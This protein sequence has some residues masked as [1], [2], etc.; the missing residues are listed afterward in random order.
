MLEIESK[1]VVD[2][3]VDENGDLILVKYDESTINAGSV[4]GPQGEQGPVGTMPVGS[5]TMFAGVTAPAGW[6]F[7]NGAE[8]DR[9]EYP[10][11]FDAIGTMYGEGD[12]ETTFNLPNMNGRVPVGLNESDVDFDTAGKTGGE[13][14]HTLTVSE[15]PSHN[16]GGT[17]GSGGAHDH[18]GST[19]SGG[20]HNH[21]GTTGSSAVVGT[22]SLSAASTNPDT[23]S[24]I[25]RGSSGDQRELAYSSHNHSIPNQ[26]A[27]THSIS[28]Q[29]AHT[30]SIG[31]QG[32]GGA[33]NNLQPFIVLNYIIQAA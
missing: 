8:V 13:K 3:S 17:T 7:C 26:A 31:S 29:A 19:G 28:N 18:G 15:M 1:S 32:G 21:G 5:V 10:L 24:A 14:E 2:G 25:Q 12:G 6:L 27:H 33:H 11:L 20:A 16:H 4:I 30:H 23:A 9:E 22:L